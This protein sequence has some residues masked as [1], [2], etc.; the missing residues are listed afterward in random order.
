M[1]RMHETIDCTWVPDKFGDANPTIDLT[2]LT[3]LPSSP[4][5]SLARPR[6][7]D[8]GPGFQHISDH[9]IPSTPDLGRLIE[10]HGSRPFYVGLRSVR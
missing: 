4:R 1:R 7:C 5:A 10:A 3:I 6:R 9:L 2:V 8:E